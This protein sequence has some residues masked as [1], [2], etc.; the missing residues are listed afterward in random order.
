MYHV[1]SNVAIGIINITKG[2]P[3]KHQE[4]GAGEPQIQK[5]QKIDSVENMQNNT[6]HVF[7]GRYLFSFLSLR[8]PL[9]NTNSQ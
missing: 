8:S 1:R 9:E 7:T 4:I 3:G 2:R 5:S 6:N